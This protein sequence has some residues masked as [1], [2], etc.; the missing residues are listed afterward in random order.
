MSS[1]LGLF[2]LLRQEDR[3]RPRHLS[4]VVA[5]APGLERQV[6]VPVRRL[7]FSPRRWVAPSG[8]AASWNKAVTA[9]R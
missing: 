5:Q 9:P 1:L 2:P 8:E 4:R 6:E 3:Q 7:P